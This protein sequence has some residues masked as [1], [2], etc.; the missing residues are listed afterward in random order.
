MTS[1]LKRQLLLW[2]LVPMLIIA[3]VAASLQYWLVLSPAKLEFD[4][5]LGDFAIAI[6]SFL[7]VKDNRLH[8][9]MTPETEHL[10]RTDQLDTEFFLV[11]GPNGKRIAGDA[12]LDT[13][14][15]GIK[16]G[17]FR[18]ADRKINNRILRMVV[19]G[20]PC[21]QDICQIRIAETLIKRNKVQA[22]ALI[23]TIMSILVLG[24]TTMGVMLVAV[25]HGLKPLQDIRNQLA[26]RSFDDLRALELPHAPSELKPLIST[27][28]QLFK[29]L[30]DA[31][32]VQK[33]FLADAAHQLR[34]P[35]TALQTESELALLEPH[36]ASLHPTLERLHHSAS[37]AGKLANQFLMIAR[38]DNDQSSAEFSCID[39]KEIGARAANEWSSRACASGVD[40]GFYLESAVVKGQPILLQELLSN[41]IHNSIEHA[42][43]GTRVTVKTHVLEHEA[44][45]EV[46]DDG[47][48]IE[49]GERQKVLQRF[50]R[51]DHAKGFGSGLGL[52]IAN[53]IARIHNAKVALNTP[54][55]GRGLLVR[56]TFQ[57]HKS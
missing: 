2:L 31:S 22:Q 17:E 45:L 4:H 57:T 43:N 44:I 36:P 7:K 24:L 46:E 49:E 51:G 50:F 13:P 25:Q 33:A 40:L 53:D 19:Y 12:L 10:L 32:T 28:N 11:I 42:G 1:S 9:E 6:A 30:A 5:Q 26:D 41:L 20:V 38:A 29:R 14:E 39:L 18:Y 23:T 21:G 35:L 56:I 34:T 16:A 47:P 3:P 15:S 27:L 37:R 48:G 52:A 54:D 8:F 55:N